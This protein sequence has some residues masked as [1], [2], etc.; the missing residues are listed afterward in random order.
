MPRKNI[1]TEKIL[2]RYLNLSIV[3]NL[4]ILRERLL[5]AQNKYFLTN[6]MGDKIT[7]IEMKKLHN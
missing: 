3:S 4:N 6:A 2:A 5:V 7:Y 1:K